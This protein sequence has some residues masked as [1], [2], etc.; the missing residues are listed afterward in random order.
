MKANASAS[1]PELIEI[2]DS[3]SAAKRKSPG[4]PFL[5]AIVGGSGSGKSWLAERLQA[6]LGPQAARISLDDFYR[7]QSHLS[8]A[9]RASLNFD[10]PDAI[11]WPSLERVLHNLLAGRTAELPCYDFKTHCRERRVQSLEPKPIVLIEGLWLLHRPSLRDLFDLKLF[12]DCPSQ[13]RLRRRIDRDVVFRGRTRAS[14]EKQFNETVEPMHRKFVAPQ[15]RWADV[16]LP[17][18]LTDYDAR[19]LAE[20]LSKSLKPV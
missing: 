8:E 1:Q 4:A 7:D 18:D 16:V 15:K 19:Q 5:V 9:D 3:G 2:A 10:H 14:V 12:I 11:D 20:R 6:V 13:T 17:F